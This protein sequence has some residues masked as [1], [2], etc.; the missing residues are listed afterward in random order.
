MEGG[1]IE[2]TGIYGAR[3]RCMWWAWDLIDKLRGLIT[4]RAR[5]AH[6]SEPRKDTKYRERWHSDLC[7]VCLSELDQDEE[8]FKLEGRAVE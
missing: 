4:G 2:P 1:M 7:E 6:C 5:C 8:K 3:V